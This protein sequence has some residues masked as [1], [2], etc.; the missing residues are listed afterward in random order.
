MNTDVFSAQAL[1]YVVPSHW[2]N[3]KQRK[4]VYR[5]RI[6]KKSIKYAGKQYSDPYKKQA[7]D[8]FVKAQIG[9]LVKRVR[10][11]GYINGIP[12]DKVKPLGRRNKY[13]EMLNLP[14][15]QV[16]LKLMEYVTRD[17]TN[18]DY[19]IGDANFQATVIGGTDKH[20]NLVYAL[21]TKE[22]TTDTTLDF[23]DKLKKNIN[24]S[25]SNVNYGELLKTAKTYMNV[26]DDDAT[27]SRRYV[28]EKP[29]LVPM[30]EE[31]AQRFDLIWDQW[32][33]GWDEMSKLPAEEQENEIIAA[34]AKGTNTGFPFFIKGTDKNLRR[35]F[36]DLC[37][38]VKFKPKIDMKGGWS[39]A[40]NR[41]Y[42][43]C[44][45]ILDLFFF[46]DDNELWLPYLLFYRIQREKHRVVC[47][48]PMDGKYIAG[49]AKS[50]FER[51]YKYEMPGSN[52]DKRASKSLVGMGG[53]PLVAKLEWNELFNIITDRLPPTD[54]IMA[55]NDVKR[56]FN[57]EVPKELEIEGKKGYTYVNVVCG[58]FSGFDTGQIPEEYE[59]LTKHKRLGKF[60][61]AVLNSLRHAEVW[62]G[63]NA[64]WDI[65]F[66]SGFFGTSDFGSFFH[67]VSTCGIVEKHFPKHKVLAHCCLS[68]DDM[69][70]VM[71]P[72][73]FHAKE[74]S[75]AY[76]LY[77]HT[78]KA[79]ASHDWSLNPILSFLKVHI[80][81]IFSKTLNV[82][83]GDPQSR[84]YNLCHS[85][86]DV[87]KELTHEE[88]I[89]YL[90]DTWMITDDVELN[91]Y[92]SKLSSGGVHYL[93]FVRL[94]FE[95]VS[96]T[97]LGD[98][99]I[100]A[101]SS[102]N[103]DEE[104]E[105]YRTDIISSFSPSC[106]AQLSVDDLITDRRRVR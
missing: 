44:D 106:L 25:S 8:N 11:G 20:I 19:H 9:T 4:G 67:H 18:T 94:H 105:Q 66:K 42:V 58:D 85:E 65:F 29:L 31:A 88:A 32:A 49:L 26:S 92:L 7:T 55:V 91:R 51:G 99:G 57:C 56:M 82:F 41:P 30:S 17:K 102:M 47:G 46:L 81:R 23:P 74:L 98:A 22:Y 35:V 5:M 33:I 69:L 87:E 83:M 86:R 36:F 13:W 15:K 48:A 21:C 89:G 52:L 50:W 12:K 53:I 54:C 100:L 73:I 95:Q 75:E 10:R 104:Y 45:L 76:A 101:V 27:R 68:D 77:G 60:F 96:G 93:P 43:T 39:K 78:I 40:D 80:G 6:I 84:Y 34:M 28:D 61:K 3:A 24:V 38:F 70:W 97:D 79:T 37:E 16:Y 103:P 62:S 2:Y 1:C 59:R 71:G 63:M 90:R 14:Q 72:T 64:F